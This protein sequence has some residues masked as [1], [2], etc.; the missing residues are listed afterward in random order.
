MTTQSKEEIAMAAGQLAEKN[1]KECTGCAQTTLAAIMDTLNI[2]NNE[3]FRSASGLA[4]GLGLSGNGTCGSL[5]AG[6]LAIG[7][8]FGRERVNFKDPLAPGKSYALVKNLHDRF[9]EKYGA[10]RC[11]DI[12]DS[13]MGRHYDLWDQQDAEAAFAGNMLDHCSKVCATA[14]ELATL[15][16]LEQQELEQDN[17]KDQGSEKP[18]AT[19]G[20]G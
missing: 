10:I 12:Q 11:N 16:I 4:D 6:A 13:L 15:I 9:Q 3:V 14:A 17:V 19:C 1:E 2:T 7:Y 18:A 20:M 5:V 8:V